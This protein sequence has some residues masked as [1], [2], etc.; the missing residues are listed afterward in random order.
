MISKGWHNF[1][2]KIQYYSSIYVHFWEVVRGRWCVG[3]VPPR[4]H[5]GSS[6]IAVILELYNMVLP[7]VFLVWVFCWYQICWAFGIFGRYCCSVSFGGNTFLRFR[8]NSFFEK[9]CWN[10]FF[11]FKRRAKC[12]KRGPGP[13]LL[14]KKGAPAIVLRG[15]RQIFDKYWPS[16]PSVLVW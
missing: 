7:A 2:L 3:G 13:P 1:P 9:F 12:T 6:S 4:P 15:S 16:F 14:R 11:F 8:G 5:P 10:S